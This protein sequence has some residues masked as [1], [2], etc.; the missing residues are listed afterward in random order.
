MSKEFARFVERF[1]ALFGDVPR[2]VGIDVLEHRGDVVEA[3]LRKDALFLGFL[4]RSADGRVDL[5]VERRVAVRI[6][7]AKRDQALE[8]AREF[9][10]RDAS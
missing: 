7:F 8:E 2:H 10:G 3:L 5:L 9:L 4:L 6:P 1:V